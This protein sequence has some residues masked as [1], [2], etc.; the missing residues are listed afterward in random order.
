MAKMPT[1]QYTSDTQ[2]CHQCILGSQDVFS[3]P[4]CHQTKLHSTHHP[5]PKDFAPA[6]GMA[7]T[8]AIQHPKE[9][10]SKEKGPPPTAVRKHRAPGIQPNT[11]TNS[12]NTTQFN[13]SQK[14]LPY[15]SLKIA[16]GGLSTHASHEAHQGAFPAL[17]IFDNDFNHTAA[18]S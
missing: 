18:A 2:P 7:T 17:F 3:I 11:K 4:G 10:K 12:N 9:V 8:C 5:V 15:P 6:K 16:P 13:S 1:F 14:P